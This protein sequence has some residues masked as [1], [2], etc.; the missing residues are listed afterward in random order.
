MSLNLPFA[1]EKIYIMLQSIMW[2]YNWE[3][4]FLSLKLIHLQCHYLEDILTLL[5]K[6]KFALVLSWLSASLYKKVVWTFPAMLTKFWWPKAQ[7]SR[8]CSPEGM[9]SPEVV[10]SDHHTF[11]LLFW[12]SYF[13][14]C[15]QMLKMS[16]KKVECYNFYGNSIWCNW[17]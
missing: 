2:R 4:K 7:V 15:F 11:S 16:H 13:F 3:S 1:P 8:L 12:H 6:V 14:E 5:L 9:C 10:W 17:L